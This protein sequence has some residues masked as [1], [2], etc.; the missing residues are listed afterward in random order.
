MGPQKGN[1]KISNNCYGED[2]P[3]KCV[4]NSDCKKIRDNV[5]FSVSQQSLEN[6][7]IILVNQE[8]LNI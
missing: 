2:A 7:E 8:M 3:L 5:A 1:S 6:V 4:I